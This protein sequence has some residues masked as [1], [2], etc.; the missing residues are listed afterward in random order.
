[1]A[2]PMR[3]RD[4]DER[5]AGRGDAR[6][7]GRCGAAGHRRFFDQLSTLV[8]LSGFIGCGNTAMHWFDPETLADVRPPPPPSCHR[9]G[10]SRPQP[11]WL[12]DRDRRGR[13]LHPRL[14]SDGRLVHE[15]VSRSAVGDSRSSPR[16]TS[17]SSSTTATYASSPSTR[18]SCSRSR[19]SLTRSFTQD[20]CDRY[21]RPVSDARG[22]AKPR[23]R[24]ALAATWSAVFRPVLVESQGT[25]PILRPDRC[26][27]PS[28]RR[29]RA[30]ATRSG[31][32]RSAAAT[33]DRQA[34]S[35][36]MPAGGSRAWRRAGPRSPPRSD[37][38]GCLHADSDLAGVVPV[39][40]D[41]M[42][43][44]LV[45]VPAA[46]T[47]TLAQLRGCPPRRDPVEHRPRGLN[48]P[49]QPLELRPRSTGRRSRSVMADGTPNSVPLAPPVCST[50][51]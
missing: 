34:A 27:L 10:R 35:R 19:E 17:A 24:S 42:A 38:S 6:S 46:A 43:D 23:K 37:G 47:G 12:A 49:R 29:G 15:L 7:A 18:T 20:E 13:R 4:L 51:S 22:H 50:T 16:V 26:G 11:G 32:R 40:L 39:G 41:D 31:G 36:P 3:S 33:C 1:M 14:G 9:D 45:A 30:S 21:G 48:Q 8:G 28:P 5:L 25:R 2:G 44:H